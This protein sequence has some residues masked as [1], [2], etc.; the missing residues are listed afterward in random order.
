MFSGLN[1]EAYDRTYTDRELVRRVATY[2]AR[3]RRRLLWT[4]LTIVALAVITAIQPLIVSEGINLLGEN[5]ATAALV[6]LVLL[7][8]LVGLRASP[9]WSCPICGWTRSRP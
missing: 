4:L 9:A 6:A 5:P 3:D 7:S 8:L 1:T 2:F